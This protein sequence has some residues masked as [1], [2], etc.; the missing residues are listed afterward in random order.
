MTE[1]ATTADRQRPGFWV[2]LWRALVKT[3]LALVVLSGLTVAGWLGFKELR[4]SF[5]VVSG[6]TDQNAVQLSELQSQLNEQGNQLDAAMQ[7]IADHDAGLT[8][9]Q[10]TLNDDIAQQEVMLTALNDQINALI[11]NS[12]T[13]SDT[14]AVMN[15]GQAA[16]QQDVIG[17]SSELDVLGGEVDGLRQQVTAVQSNEAAF[18]ESIAAFEA[19]ITAADPASLRQAIRIFR[20]WELLTRAR[21]R[22]AEQNVGL[23]S[24]DLLLAQT[25]LANLLTDDP[26][27]QADALTAA[28]ERLQMAIDR[29]PDEPT[30]AVSDLNIAWQELDQAL[31]SLLGEAA[32]AQPTP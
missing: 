8:A 2:R 16:L 28:A 11:A 30:T 29:L 26:A 25:A 5:D 19:E 32:T 9:L 17:H 23:A 21:V 7:A 18:A 24:A 20:V 27:P 6:R 12:A 31:A 3:V 4:R 13:M 14:L 10:T 15:E 22:L 1:E